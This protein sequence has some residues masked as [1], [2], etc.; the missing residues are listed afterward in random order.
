MKTDSEGN[1]EWDKTF[2]GTDWDRT[3]SVQQT[4]DGGYILAGTTRS[5]G[6]GWEDF[7]LVKFRIPEQE[8][9]LAIPKAGFA[10]ESANKIGADITEAQTLRGQAETATPHIKYQ[11]AIRYATQ[12]KTSAMKSK[13][14]QLDTCAAPPLIAFLIVFLIVFFLIAIKAAAN[15]R[16][17]VRREEEWF[18]KQVHEGQELY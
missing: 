11:S 1:K 13:T 15:A 2:G 3:H 17:R 18:R 16:K 4:T 7:W 6:A 14:K 12:A 8:A 5:Y 9:Q 10:I